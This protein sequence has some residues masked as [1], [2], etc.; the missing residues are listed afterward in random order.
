MPDDDDVTDDVHDDDDGPGSNYQPPATQDDLNRI[1]EQRLARERAKYADYDQLKADADR[2]RELEYE[3][4][5]ETE[6]AVQSA[7][8]DAAQR[9]QSQFLPRLVQA[10]MKAAAAGRIPADEL[11]DLI[12]PLDLSKFVQDG[13]V[14]TARVAAW[15]DR[16]APQQ[17]SSGPSATGLGNR[18]GQVKLSP[19]EIAAAQIAKRFPS[20]SK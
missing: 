10:E 7:E 13:E 6:K 2:M 19:R 4:Q 18:G 9:A 15:V 3:L 5:S 16:V 12:E 14:N 17:R 11:A 8:K 20:A 1:I